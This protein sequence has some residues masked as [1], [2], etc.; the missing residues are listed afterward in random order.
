MH[1]LLKIIFPVAVFLATKLS[2]LAF[3]P[4]GP[5]GPAPALPTGN[6]IT[7]DV[8]EYIIFRIS[9]FLISTSG[10]LALIFIIWS[11]VTYM[12]A[13]DDAKKIETAKARLRSGIIGAAVVLGVGVIIQT[14]ASV[15]TLD[16]FCTARIPVVGVCVY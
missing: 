4:F 16:F 11:G 12:Y 2:A 3:N 1:Y 7:L 8:L 15:V 5:A 9:T 6:P 14:I 13:G 10:V